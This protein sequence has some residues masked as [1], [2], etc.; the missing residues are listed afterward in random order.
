MFQGALLSSVR[1]FAA[2]A[3]LPFLN[4]KFILSRTTRGIIVFLTALCLSGNEHGPAEFSVVSILS[5]MITGT[6]MGLVYSTPFFIFAAFGEYIDNQR[7]ANI[8]DTADPTTGTDA[9]PFS[10][11][12]NLFS[13]SFF[14]LNDG[15]VL[16]MA[17]VQDSFRLL[18][19]GT[20]LTE[21]HY[22]PLFDW[23]TNS[24]SLSLLFCM[25]VLIILFISEVSLGILAL[26]NSQLNPFSLSLSIKSIIAFLLALL[27]FRGTTVTD[28]TLLFD[29]SPVTQFLR[30]NDG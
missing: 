16:L 8:S 22:A 6:V 29:T 9:S 27:L 24:L 23:L 12:M 30:G 2:F 7:G 1:L 17:S 28:V 20:L 19:P 25:P 10:T 21:I 14:L 26:Y 11:F 3:F 15:L 13:V 5:E 4:D 18:P